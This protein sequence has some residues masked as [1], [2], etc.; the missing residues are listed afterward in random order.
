MQLRI[1]DL[2]VLSGALWAC[3]AWA[4]P[5]EIQVYTN[6]INYPGQ[7]GL[8]LHTNDVLTGDSTPAYPGAQSDTG[9]IRLTPEWSY[10]LDDHFELGA[11]LPLTTLDD[12]GRYRVDG[13]KFRLK[14]LGQHTE[15]GFYYGINY[16]IGREDYHLDQ[17]PWNNEV[18]LIAGWEGDHWLIGS[19]VNFD[20]ALSGPARTPPQVELDAKLGYKL[21]EDTLIGFETYNGAGTTARFGR[22]GSSEQSSFIAFDT[23]LGSKWD[24]NLGA[25]R[26]YG[27]NPDGW[28]VKMIVGV[29]FGH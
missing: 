26:G 8:E 16:E 19:N 24:L 3:P 1:R 2:V 7:L 6:E 11:Y 17:N 28:I 20:F 9:R 27:T 25:G 15:R 14:W 13:Y 22:F 4:A 23:K 18:K 5:E 10:G 21:K 12:H 29:A